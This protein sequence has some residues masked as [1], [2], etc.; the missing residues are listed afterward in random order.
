MSANGE[1]GSLSARSEVV[2]RRSSRCETSS[3]VEVAAVGSGIGVRG[4]DDA[5][6]V[7]R[8]S[9]SEWAAFVAGVKAGDFDDL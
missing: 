9:R 7:V 5:Q 2:W 4:T 1:N 8:V 6:V 3:C